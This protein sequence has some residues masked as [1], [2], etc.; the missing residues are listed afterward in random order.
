[1]ITKTSWNLYIIIIYSKKL[2]SRHF[3]TRCML[4]DF[5]FT[6]DFWKLIILCFNQNMWKTKK[7][8][9]LKIVHL[10]ENYDFFHLRNIWKK[11]EYLNHIIYQRVTEI[12]TENRAP[13]AS[14]MM[15]MCSLRGTSIFC[16]QK[17]DFL[18]IVR[19]YGWIFIEHAFAARDARFILFSFFT[20]L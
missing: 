10:N 16:V 5:N 4:F 15:R 1:M 14:V 17:I 13:S 6:K 18:Y 9:N 2:L 3:L 12:Y 8:S 7:A 20:L 19:I 11:I